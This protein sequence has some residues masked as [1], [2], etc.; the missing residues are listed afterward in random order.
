LP[1]LSPIATLAL[2]RSYCALLRQRHDVL[3]LH[4]YG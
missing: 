3:L 1:T 2:H 4:A